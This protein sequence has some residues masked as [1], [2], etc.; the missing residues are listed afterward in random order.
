VP[1]RAFIEHAGFEI[2]RA[3]YGSL[4]IYADYICAK[5]SR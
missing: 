3:D 4:K 1:T 5:T 2:G